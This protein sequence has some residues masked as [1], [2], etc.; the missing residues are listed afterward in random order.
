MATSRDKL[1][2]VL[3]IIV[4]LMGAEI[5]YLVYQNQKLR[6]IIDDPKNYFQTLAHKESVPSIN[7]HDVYGNEV[8][9][10]YGVDQPITVLFWFSPGCAA[11]ESNFPFWNEMYSEYT[12][13]SIRFYGMCLGGID[14]AKEFVE[15][16]GIKFPVIAATD[17]YI[18]E[19]YKGNV[20]PQTVVVYPDGSVA[21]AWPGLLDGNQ[22]ELV[23]SLLT[24]TPTTNRQGGE[25]R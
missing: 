18:V 9:L 11:C 16:T 17:S 12:D 4:V 21:G 20:L 6:S 3:M 24:K 1:M 19:S 13:G 2:I 25:T 7:A 15:S 23:L 22:E 8:S 5:I 10:R 14:E